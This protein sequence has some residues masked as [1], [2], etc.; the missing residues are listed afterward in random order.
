MYCLQVR[1]YIFQPG[2]FTGCG[3]EGVNLDLR[4]YVLPPGHS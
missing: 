2:H 1:P 3:S 4:I